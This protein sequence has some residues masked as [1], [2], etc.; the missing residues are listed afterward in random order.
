MSMTRNTSPKGLALILRIVAVMVFCCGLVWS[1]EI[2]VAPAGSA[3]TLPMVFFGH[4]VVALCLEPAAAG[5]CLLS[6][7][8][9]HLAAL[10]HHSRAEFQERHPPQ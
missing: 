7:C 6:R 2:V 3:F 4:L 5:L 1:V 8:E 10:Q 9:T